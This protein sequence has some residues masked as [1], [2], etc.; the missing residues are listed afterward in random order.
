MWPVYLKQLKWF[1]LMQPGTLNSTRDP[2][3]SP[4]LMFFFKLIG[5]ALALF[6]GTLLLCYILRESCCFLTNHFARHNENCTCTNCL[7]SNNVK[8]E[9]EQQITSFIT[10]DLNCNIVHSYWNGHW[11]FC[12]ASVARATYQLPISTRGIWHFDSVFSPC[13]LGP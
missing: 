1:S 9:L 10:S 2:D 6:F 4:A 7:H 13:I 11:W 3:W 5:I 8:A 12:P